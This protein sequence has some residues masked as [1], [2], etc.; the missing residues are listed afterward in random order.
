MLSW[1][2]QFDTA[3]ELYQ[4]ILRQ[5]GANTDALRGLADTLFW[6]GAPRDA[7]VHYARLAQLTGDQ[8][9]AARVQAITAAMEASPRAPLGLRDSTLRLPYRDYLTQQAEI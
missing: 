2:R 9:S 7:L 6:S 1:Q 3:I 5:D 8:E 4:N